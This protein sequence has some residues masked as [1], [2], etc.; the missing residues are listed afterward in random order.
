MQQLRMLC[1]LAPPFPVPLAYA[2]LIRAQ[3]QC[4]DMMTLPRGADVLA[5]CKAPSDDCQ[6]PDLGYCPVVFSAEGV[7]WRLEAVT[8]SISPMLTNRKC[9]ANCPIKDSPD[10]RLQQRMF[11]AL[12]QLPTDPTEAGFLAL[13]LH[14]SQGESINT[15]Y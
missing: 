14:V 3:L 12:A 5:S 10:V 7:K 15:V 6:Q 4:L 11:H 13:C 9:N 8:E 1:S 2:V